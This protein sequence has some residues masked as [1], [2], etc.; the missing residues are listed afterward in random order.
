MEVDRGLALGELERLRQEIDGHEAVTMDL[1]HTV[2]GLKLE[3]SKLQSESSTAQAENNTKAAL[4]EANRSELDGV[5][6]KLREAHRDIR[7]LTDRLADAETARKQAAESESLALEQLARNRDSL[8]AQRELREKLKEQ[9]REL[10]LQYHE[11]AALLSTVKA[12]KE[13]AE[14]RTRDTGAGRTAQ[15]LAEAIS[16]TRTLEHEVEELSTQLRAAQATSAPALAEMQ[17]R[18]DSME[19]ELNSSRAHNDQLEGELAASK[20]AAAGLSSAGTSTALTYAGSRRSESRVIRHSA[21]AV[22]SATVPAL[23]GQPGLLILFNPDTDQYDLQYTQREVLETDDNYQIDLMEATSAF[24]I[25]LS[26]VVTNFNLGWSRSQLV[27]NSTP[28]PAEQAVFFIADGQQ[29]VDDVAQWAAF[30]ATYWRGLRSRVEWEPVIQ[31]N[32]DYSRTTVIFMNHLAS[33]PPWQA[34]PASEPGGSGIAITPVEM[35]AP[36]VSH[37][38]SPAVTYPPATSTPAAALDAA[39]ASGDG[40]KA[41]ALIASLGGSSKYNYPTLTTDRSK[42]DAA[43]NY[44]KEIGIKRLHGWAQDP[45][46]QDSRF[47]QEVPPSFKWAHGGAS[48]KHCCPSPGRFWYPSLFFWTR[49]PKRHRKRRPP[50][51]I[52]GRRYTSRSCAKACTVA[53]HRPASLP[54]CGHASEQSRSG[55]CKGWCWRNLV[56]YAI[57]SICSRRTASCGSRAS[58]GR[59]Q[60]PFGATSPSYTT[61]SSCLC[62]RTIPC[63]GGLAFSAEPTTSGNQTGRSTSARTSPC[64]RKH[65]WT[66]RI[67]RALRRECRWT[68][69]TRT[70][71]V[72]IWSRSSCVLTSSQG[73]VIR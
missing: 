28:T 65:M 54:T 55:M 11:L 12:E 33:Q 22:Y 42:V 69:F 44:R 31:D 61:S 64:L 8:Q 1:R 21:I 38:A 9:H 29:L 56:Q 13:A 41:D 17:A 5:H 72:A 30:K 45:R 49:M 43:S 6:A 70:H 59:G 26:G 36:A 4:I 48:Q 10:E 7:L 50:L 23:A 67:P 18:L 2:V 19:Q 46:H 71:T 47:F 62:A 52:S 51:I 66:G 39:P 58:I 73:R 68:P 20:A 35:A 32:T 37:E 27:L 24:E 53:Y 60:E 40:S 3:I 57:P 16:R 34:A 14:E 25:G 15:A 63:L